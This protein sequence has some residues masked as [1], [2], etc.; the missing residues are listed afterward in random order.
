MEM[1]GSERLVH[2]LSSRLDRSRFSPSIAWFQ[3]DSALD[4]FKSLGVPLYHIPKLKR[5]DFSVIKALGE[6]IRDNAIDI[7]NPQ[8]FMPM[9]YSYYGSKITNSKRLVY[10]LH[11]KWEIEMLPFRWKIAARTIL[12][13]SDGIIGVNGSITG[14]AQKFFRIPGSKAFTILNGVDIDAY[15]KSDKRG[16]IRSRLGIKDNEKAIGM[17]ANLKKVKNHSMLLNA[18]NALLKEYKD[19]KL[20]LIGEGYDNDPENTEPEIKEFI[21]QRGLSDTVSL[22]GYRDDVADILNG[23]DIFCLTSYKEG[24]PISMIEAMAA[25]LPLVGTDVDGIRD[26]VIPERNGLLVKIDDVDGLKNTLYN[27]LKDEHLRKKMGLESKRMTSETYSLDACIKHY[28]DLFT[29]LVQGSPGPE[30]LS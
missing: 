19:I 14:Y 18:F 1:G 3:G 29:G 16:Y 22:L 15:S 5:I 12:K 25:G 30:I 6:L 20:L 9:V 13:N 24:L 10:T 7:V 2:T 23:L 4:E 26:V 21:K 28:E 8:H 27:L 17:V 11:S